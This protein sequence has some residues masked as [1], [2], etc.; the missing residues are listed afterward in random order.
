MRCRVHR[1][2]PIRNIVT[3]VQPTYLPHTFAGDCNACKYAAREIYQTF[4][5]LLRYFFIRISIISRLSYNIDVHKILCT[6]IKKYYAK[7]LY[8]N[9]I[10][11]TLLFQWNDDF[12]IGLPR[13]C[14]IA[15]V[16]SD[17]IKNLNFIRKIY[18]QQYEKIKRHARGD[19]WDKSTLYRLYSSVSR[20]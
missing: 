16:E 11:Y 10:L 8:F 6:K 19:S 2:T 20:G 12:N 18:V 1:E 13:P 14:S 3:D 9:V 17:G 15:C 7:R 4:L 5:I